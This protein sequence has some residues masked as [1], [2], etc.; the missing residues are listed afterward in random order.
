MFIKS[1]ILQLGSSLVT[2]SGG[3]GG[4]GQVSTTT[5][6]GGN[7]RI[8]LEYTTILGST[9]PSAG[10]TGTFPTT[11][12]GTTL[13]VNR[14]DSFGK[15]LQLLS[16]GTEMLG[17]DS[18][19]NFYLNSLQTTGDAAS[20]SA[21]L[22]TSGN[23]LKLSSSSLSTGNLV[24]L[25]TTLT[26]G[27]LLS[28]TVSGITTGNLINITEA[29]ISNFSGT[30]ILLNL[31]QDLQN[32]T[33]AGFTGKFLEFINAATTAF[34]VDAGGKITSLFGASSDPSLQ[35]NGQGF[36][37]SGFGKTAITDS[38][39]TLGNGADGACTL[40][41]TITLDAASANTCVSRA[42]ADAVN[43]RLANLAV[44]GSTSITVSSTP[45]GLAVND[46]ILIINLRDVNN[47]DSALYASSDWI[48][49]SVGKY[50]T[51]R[52]TAINTNTLTLDG[53][54]VHAYDGSNYSVMVQ[55]VPNYTTVTVSSGGTMTISAFSTSTQK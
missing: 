33:G 52:I 49:A 9:S 26:T 2:A 27:N 44:S 45:T 51:H 3:T 55:R 46:E 48:N 42:N 29:G 40:S 20:I 37:V 36:D 23:L 28:A 25:D 8:R 16:G 53:P 14:Q 30:G 11:T 18:S 43:F 1:S 4:T 13:S 15:L 38:T 12:P 41:S 6:D 10:S 47:T 22:L 5:G 19:G 54:L 39:I 24:R 50:E 31:A 34:V 21:N 17:V 35:I 32:A 7:G